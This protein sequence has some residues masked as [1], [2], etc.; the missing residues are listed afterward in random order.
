[1]APTFLGIITNQ[2]ACA[3]GGGCQSTCIHP[4]PH[5]DP[6]LPVSVESAVTTAP[7]EL[8]PGCHPGPGWYLSIDAAPCA[9]G[10]RGAAPVSPWDCHAPGCFCQRPLCLLPA[11]QA[12]GDRA[13]VRQCAVGLR[14]G[15]SFTEC[16]VSRWDAIPPLATNR[17]DSET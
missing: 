8:H 3:M 11:W 9:H 2:A 13:L 1:M 4:Y 6:S 10:A 17:N 7:K 5:H 12:P 16:T 14:M 15:M